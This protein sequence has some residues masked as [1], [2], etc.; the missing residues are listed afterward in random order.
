MVDPYE[1]ADSGG[2]VIR[3]FQ[4]V[5]VGVRYAQAFSATTNIDQ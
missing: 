3:A 5:D 4:S 1:K 2:I